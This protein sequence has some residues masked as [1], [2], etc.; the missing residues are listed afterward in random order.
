MQPS[1]LLVACAPTLSPDSAAAFS[2]RPNTDDWSF[3]HQRWLGILSF[4]F[5]RD[6]HSGTR[7]ASMSI[8]AGATSIAGGPA[9]DGSSEAPSATAMVEAPLKVSGARQ[10]PTSPQ[11]RS[12]GELRAEILAEQA[13]S[14]EY[15]GEQLRR[16]LAALAAAESG[17]DR[18]IALAAAR[19]AFWNLM[20]QRDAIGFRNS[21]EVVSSYGVP[22]VVTQAILPA[23][24]VPLRQWP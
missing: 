3:A 9:R 13:A 23:P 4:R 14:L 8:E 21:D 20:V 1:P 17:E 7:A 12:F 2:G 24:L 16:G 11:A 19:E 5:T 18:T 15:A 10:L 22:A 6:I